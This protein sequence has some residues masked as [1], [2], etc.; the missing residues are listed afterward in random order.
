MA[1]RITRSLFVV[2]AATVLSAAVFSMVAL[3]AAQA[4]EWKPKQITIVLPHSLG[5]GQD[6]LTRVLVKVWAKK[7]GAKLKVLNKTGASGRIGFDYFRTQPQDGTVL[8]TTNIATTGIMYASQKPPWKWQD[9][10]YQLGVF[11]VDPGAVFVL[12]D[13]PYKSIKDVIAAGQKK[14][15]VFALS[16]WRSTENMTIHQLMAQKKASFQVIPI[17]GGS[18]LVT[19]VLGGHVPVGL[20]KV[21]NIQKGGDRVRVLAVA[22]ATNPVPG[23]TNNAPTLDGALGTKTVPVASYRSIL[24]PAALPKKYPD[25]LKKLKTTFEATKDDPEY[26]KLAK[27]VGIAPANILDMDHPEMLALLGSFWGAFDKHGAFFKTKLK[28]TKVSSKLL[29][30]GKKGKKV[31]FIDTDGKKKKIKV[32]RRR[33]KV[34]IGGKRVKGKK[35]LKMLKAG[36]ECEIGYI[37]VPVLAKHLKCK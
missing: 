31:T 36:M 37:G 34:Y 13:S 11:G 10:F 6:R 26:I 29:K 22:L 7:L 30:V 1:S 21:S 20:G 4:G 8:L 32:H 14:T 17:G 33:T 15:T 19:A 16:S 12:K 24:V 23:M 18:D 3:S 2:A 35:G 28:M 9:T 25:R 27:K 5:G